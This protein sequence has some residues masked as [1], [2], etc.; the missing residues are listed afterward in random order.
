MEIINNSQF[1]NLLQRLVHDEVIIDSANELDLLDYHWF[2]ISILE[3]IE[4]DGNLEILRNSDGR[5]E[6]YKIIQANI[7]DNKLN[8]LTLQLE[9]KED[10][11]I[12]N[13][14][15]I[16]SKCDDARVGGDD[17]RKYYIYTEEEMYRFVIK[18]L[19]K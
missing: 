11:K 14:V 18:L 9:R 10:G 12:N 1:S 5:Y 7:N 17:F 6:N 3:G 2:L 4:R 8:E 16:V 15:F 13:H 19:N